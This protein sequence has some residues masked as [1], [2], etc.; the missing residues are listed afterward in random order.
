M[1]SLAA[2]G[3]SEDR[4]ALAEDPVA[5]ALGEALTRTGRDRTQSQAPQAAVDIAGL[6]GPPEASEPPAS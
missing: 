5:W 6:P 2:P 1:S 4:L 3:A